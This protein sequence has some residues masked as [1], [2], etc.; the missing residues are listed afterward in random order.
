MTLGE[1]RFSS[2][3]NFILVMLHSEDSLPENSLPDA[4]GK[5]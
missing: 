3:L 4:C 1:H 2:L 5:F